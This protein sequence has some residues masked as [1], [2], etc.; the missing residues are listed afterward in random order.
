M[1]EALIFLPVRRWFQVVNHSYQ[2]EIPW[3]MKT[4]NLFFFFSSKSIKNQL[5][6]LHPRFFDEQRD[7]CGTIRHN[8][9]K[10]LLLWL[11]YNIVCFLFA[12]SSNPHWRP[13]W[14]LNASP[15][16]SENQQ[17]HF[18]NIPVNPQNYGNMYASSSPN[19]YSNRRSTSSP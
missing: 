6:F 5:C 16:S 2:E 19:R 9:H 7:F 14:D 1:K 10:Y 11:I 4:S 12:E 18:N 3:K 8:L 13:N 17:E 15:Q